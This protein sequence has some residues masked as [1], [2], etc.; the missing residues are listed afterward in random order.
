M[1]DKFS[2]QTPLTSA[3]LTTPGTFVIGC[4]YWASHAGT[5]MWRD[6]QPAVV[7][8]DFQRL[9]AAGMQLL[10][11][12]PLWPD[13]QP[14]TASRTAN[15]RLVEFSFGDTPLP[16]DNW[17]QAGISAAAIAH[18]AAFL[19]LA[20]KYELKF[21]IGLLTGWMSGRLYLPPALEGL[22]PLTDPL[23][24]QWEIRFVREFV[25]NFRDHPAI[26]GW[27]LGNECNC[28][29]ETTREQAYLWAATIANTI[30][31]ADPIRPVISGMHS[32]TPEGNWR[33]Q[34]QGELTDLLTTHPYPLFTPHCDQD[35]INTIRTLMHGTAESRLY[36]DLGGKPCFCQETGTLGPVNASEAIA[37][38]FARTCLFSLWAHDCH[39]MLWWCAHE[40]TELV[41][42]PYEW[43][44]LERELGLLRTDGSSKPAMESFGEFRHFLETLPFTNLPARRTEAVCLLSQS[45]DQWGTAFSSFILAKQAGF[46]LTFCYHG[47]SLPEA[48][49]YLLPNV[50]GTM[51][52]W[53]SQWRE[54]LARVERGAT[55]YISLNDALL[56]DF[57]KV[58]GLEPQT[59]ERRRDFSPLTLERLNDAPQIPQ[60]GSSKVN[61]RAV[62]ATVLGHE[63]DGNPAFSV[64][65]YGAGKVYFLNSPL[66]LT[67][68][69]TPGVFHSADAL[70][71]WRVYQEIA[72]GVLAT[73]A[74]R[75]TNPLVAITEHDMAD[76]ARLI[77]AINESPE[78]ITETFTLHAGWSLKTTYRGEFTTTAQNIVTQLP[79]N[80]AVV[81][82]V[83]E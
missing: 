76:G 46:D 22:N 73:R 10:R 34:D 32:L 43:T 61:L 40:Q 18:F 64:A 70:P 5:N 15:G 60:G 6:W 62:G 68:A 36:A 33:M 8:Q 66:E 9:A 42:P 44:A 51:N 74:V 59:R 29:G 77:I 7:E 3:T 57:A 47:Q 75:K 37:A 39:G 48:E 67:L 54:L 35:P 65:S 1:T 83:G 58:I 23:A 79:K 19:D 55:L 50:C 45:Q 13:F 82:V 2:S 53:Q 72:Q 49:L 16:T 52:V 25:S 41:H 12:F 17:G 11:V 28:M 4:N 81:F 63:V 69:Q 24:I 20:A 78:P 80:D 30:H 31:V 21:I 26:I 38:D 56:P 27:D 14:I 71:S